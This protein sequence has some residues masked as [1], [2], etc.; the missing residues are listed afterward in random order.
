MSKN[1]LLYYFTITGR[2]IWSDDQWSDTEK[3]EAFKWLNELTHRTWNIKRRVHENENDS[4]TDL[5]D[6]LKFYAK[7]SDLLSSHLVPTF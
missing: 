1:H 3:V 6:H 2:G 5:Y 4:I 7:Q